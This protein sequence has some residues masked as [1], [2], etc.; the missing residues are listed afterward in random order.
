MLPPDWGQGYANVWLGT[1]VENQVEA[2][3]RVPALMH[4]PA[5]LRFLSCEPL[6]GP[7]HLGYLGW[8]DPSDPKPREGYNGLLGWRYEKGQMVEQ[9]GKI[10]WVITGGESGPE[11]RPANHDWFRM[12]RD[13]CDAVGI[14]FLFKQWEGKS[15]PEIKKLGRLLDGKLHDGYPASPALVVQDAAV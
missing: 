7:V 11:Y 9:L 3:R 10:D 5:R 6:L 1:T 12:L 13:Q 8:P 14:P 2:D 15:Q 4:A